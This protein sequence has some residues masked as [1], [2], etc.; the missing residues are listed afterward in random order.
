MKKVYGLIACDPNGVMGKQGTLPWHIPD[1]LAHFA[2]TIQNFPL[3]MGHLTYLSMPSRYFKE[4]ISI[5]FSRQK[6][7]PAY[8]DQYFVT[9]LAEC[10]ALIESL[11]HDKFFVIGGAQIISLFLQNHLIDE[12]LLTILKNK[13]EG[14]TFFPLTLL[15]GWKEDT[16][17]ET[18]SFTIHRYVKPL[19]TSHADQNP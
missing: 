10:R 1:E 3:I 19:E 14:D 7:Q 2:Q 12:F 4:R 6:L 15:N 13:Y 16:I 11:S 5:I 9:S 8:P 17:R 18:S